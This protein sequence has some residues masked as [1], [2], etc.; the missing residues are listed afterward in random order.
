MRIPDNVTYP[1][2]HAERAPGETDL[3][4][5]CPE[6][7]VVLVHDMQRYFLDFFAPD[8]SP[9]KE[10]VAHT[11]ALVGAARAAGVPV[12]YTAQ[13]GAMSRQD[14]GL[15]H[16]VWGPGMTAD[17]AHQ[18]ILPEVA[19]CEGETVLTKWRY[20]AFAR[21]DLL[22][23]LAAMERD[24]LVIC[25]VYAHIGC[26]ITAVDAFTSD[27]Q[28]FLVA[29]AL[30]DFTPEYHALALEYAA[31]RCAATPTSAELLWV[32]KGARADGGAAGARAVT[33]HA[34]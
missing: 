5:L 28:P 12:L 8:A 30:A 18:E 23:R 11:A 26:L 14:R 16:D 7:A 6:R 13:P 17:P 15:L 27:I 25:G 10:L 4:R 2:P 33:S 31:E 1:M 29:D 20:S 24:Q 34:G 32:L 21:T 22:T 19:P 3:W 9:R